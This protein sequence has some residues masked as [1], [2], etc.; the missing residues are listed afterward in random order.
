MSGP[1]LLCQACATT[2]D[3]ILV[4]LGSQP[5]ANAYLESTQLEQERSYPLVV[6]VCS[7]CLLV[8]ADHDIPAEAIFTDSYAY[9]SSYSSSWVEHARRFASAA[10]QRFGLGESSQVIEVASNDGYLLQHFQDQHIPVLGIEPTK[11]TASAALAKGIPTETVFFSSQSARDLL[12]RG[13]AAD[14]MVANNVLAH[15]PDI[16]DF[17]RGFAV[18]L[19]PK[20]VASFEFPHLLNLIRLNQ[21]DTIYHEHYCYLSLTS[22]DGL[23]ASCGLQIFDVEE[24]STHGGSLRVFAGRADHSR[25]RSRAVARVLA[26]ESEAGLDRIEGY[27]GYKEAVLGVRD[28]FLEFLARARREN[29]SVAGYGAAAKGNTFLNYCRI[30]REDLLCVAD[31]SSSKQG[32]LLPGSHIPIVTPAELIARRPDYVI[33][34]PWNLTIEITRSMAQIRSWGGRFVVAIPELRIL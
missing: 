22:L 13:F 8:Q 20:G 3:E 6:R 33:I 17:L 26:S 9:F 1:A 16:T 24:L 11:N 4:D 5:L 23:F 7:K 15:V 18:L 31:L 21:F 32:K 2:L 27:R 30:S 12:A 28:Q 29:K 14:L 34:L 25:E 10:I 19:E